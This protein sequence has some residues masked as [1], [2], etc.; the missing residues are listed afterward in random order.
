MFT[1][2]IV[3]VLVSLRIASTSVV[4]K[5]EISNLTLG[6]GEG[7][8]CETVALRSLAG[9]HNAT[10]VQ[11]IAGAFGGRGRGRGRGKGSSEPLVP[12]SCRFTRE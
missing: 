12:D 8:G 1:A 5:A 7:P 10:D 2:T 9:S 6:L 4:C 3:P 11:L